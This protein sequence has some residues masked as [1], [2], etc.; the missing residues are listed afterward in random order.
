MRYRSV[1]G[2]VEIECQLFV[3]SRSSQMAIFSNY[4]NQPEGRN[5]KYRWFC[6]SLGICEAHVLITV[7]SSW[8][9]VVWDETSW[10]PSNK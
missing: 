9:E 2:T 3:M 8:S 4:A 6:K 10:N 1:E 7:N 5:R